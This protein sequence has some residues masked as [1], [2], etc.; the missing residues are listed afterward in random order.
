M[1]TNKFLEAELYRIAEEAYKGVDGDYV[2]DLCKQCAEDF[3]QN[4][5]EVKRRVQQ[6][7]HQHFVNV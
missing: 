4:F 3:N 6:F 7:Y 5:D 1:I 2:D